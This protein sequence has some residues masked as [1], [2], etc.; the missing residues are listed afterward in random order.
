MVTHSPVAD[1]DPSP[2][3]GAMVIILAAHVPYSADCFV[4]RSVLLAGTVGIGTVFF[5]A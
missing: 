5:A 4:T 1:L 2:A 3:D